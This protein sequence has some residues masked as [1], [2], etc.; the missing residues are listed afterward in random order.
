MV[1]FPDAVT[2]RVL[3]TFEPERGQPTVSVGRIGLDPSTSARIISVK[4]AFGGFMQRPILGYGVTG[5]AFMDQQ[6][7]RTLVETGVVG[8]AALL[9]LVWAVLKVG[10]GSFRALTDPE[11]RGLALGFVAA[12]FGLLGHALGANTF[13]I[14][15]IMEPFWFF[16]AIV[17][18]LPT[19]AAAEATA[20]RASPAHAFRR[21]A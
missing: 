6:F 15:R 18:A 9:G 19:L 13:I 21:F 3:Y 7:A 2:K 10:V 8:L 1:L 11:E 17:I 20:P 12:T 16:A 5:F 14:V 4:Q